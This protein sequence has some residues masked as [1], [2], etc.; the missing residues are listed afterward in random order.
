MVKECWGVYLKLKKELY[1]VE[2]FLEVLGRLYAIPTSVRRDVDLS[3]AFLH[4]L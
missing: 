1:T 3:S 4:K 2:W